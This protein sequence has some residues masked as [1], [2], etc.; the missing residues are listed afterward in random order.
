[1][2]VYYDIQYKDLWDLHVYVNVH[3]MHTSYI[4]LKG[5]EN[6]HENNNNLFLDS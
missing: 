4:I 6:L 1:M 3:F 5:V 2:L